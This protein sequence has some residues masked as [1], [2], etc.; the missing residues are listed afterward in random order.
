MKLLRP[1]AIALGCLLATGASAQI[2]PPPPAAQPPPAKLPAEKEAPKAAPKETS[3]PKVPVAAKKPASPKPAVSPTPAPTPT[4]DDPNVDLV[5][6]AYQRG[7]YK[8]AF[9]LAMTRATYARDPKAMTMLGELYA[10][11]LGIKR[12]YAKAAEWYQRASDAGDREGMFALAMMR[13]SGRGGPTNREEAVKLL[14]SS[15][16]LGNPRR[17]II[18]RCSISTARRCRRI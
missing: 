11:A 15:A 9:D 6:G 17:R 16:K 1:I 3:K 5:Y 14:A 8:T 4:F 10:N 2:S 13:L 18:W 12:D 7:L